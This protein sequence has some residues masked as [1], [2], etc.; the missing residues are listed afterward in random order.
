MV[1]L[2]DEERAVVGAEVV[3]GVSVELVVV[4]VDDVVVAL[5]AMVS[6]DV[7][8][9]MGVEEDVTVETE[10]DVVGVEDVLVVVVA[11]ETTETVLRP[12]FATN[13]SFVPES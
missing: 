12:K 9:V 8:V 13:S 10:P 1:V 2:V 5:V 6:E 11:K 7:V 4:G 3:V